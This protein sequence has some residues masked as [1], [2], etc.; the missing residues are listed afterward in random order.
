MKRLHS[1]IISPARVLIY[2]APTDIGGARRAPERCTPRAELRRSSRVIIIGISDASRQL[3]LFAKIGRRSWGRLLGT[4]PLGRHGTSSFS[5]LSHRDA[6]GRT[7]RLRP[8]TRCWITIAA[9]APGE[10]MPGQRRAARYHRLL[11]AALHARRDDA[12]TRRRRDM[13]LRAPH[14]VQPSA[15]YRQQRSRLA[16]ACFTAARPSFTSSCGRRGEDMPSGAVHF[17]HRPAE[18]FSAAALLAL[19]YMR[20]LARQRRSAPVGHVNY[21]RSILQKNECHYESRRFRP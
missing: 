10:T 20:A 9:P 18:I 11:R 2:G 14:A 21:W 3:R 8:K 4:S 6:V 12:A 7:G 5:S 15:A 19:T 17:R 13:L 1:L 16:R